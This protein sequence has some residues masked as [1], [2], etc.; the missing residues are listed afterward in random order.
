MRRGF[1]SRVEDSTFELN[2]A[3]M[4]DIIV[5]IVPMLLMSLAFVHVSM[6][7]T[8]VPQAVEKAIAAQNDK[9][10]Q[11][12]VTLHV[13]KQSG[14]RFAVVDKGATKE[15]V[16][17]MKGDK[18]DL[19]GL[20]KETLTLKQSYPDVFRIE[21]NPSEDVALDDIVKVMDEVRNVAKGE[22]K[23]TFKDVDTGK[24]VETNLMFPDIVFGN[25][26]GG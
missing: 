20:H 19:E 22:A 9:K 7:E 11:V 16:V 14:F 13:S 24:P 3:P 1:S 23:V 8:P 21:L 25:V 10:D 5:S 12:S 18:L 6:I 4:L 26:A 17:A 15:T 2:L